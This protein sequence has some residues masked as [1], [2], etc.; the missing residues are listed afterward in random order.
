MRYTSILLLL[1]IN[2]TFAQ[3]PVSQLKIYLEKAPDSSKIQI[4]LKISKAYE[5]GR[6]DSAI[7]YCSKGIRLAEIQNNE[8]EQALFLLQIGRI[9]TI[10]FQAELGRKFENEA[11]LT[12]MRIR[13]QRGIA[14]CYS[15]LALVDGLEQDTAAT[16]RNFDKAVEIYRSVHDKDGVMET[17][18]REGNFYEE[19]GET[20]NALRYYLQAYAMYKRQKEK[21]E[22]YFT[23]I[24]HIGKLYLKKGANDTAQHYL[25]EG[26]SNVNTA[27]INN[28]QLNLIDEEGKA[29]EIER[30]NDRALLY[31]KQELATAKKANNFEQQAKALVS[32]AEILMKENTSQSIITLQNALSIAKDFNLP[33]LESIIYKALADDYRLKK[34]YKDAMTA[35]EEHEYLLDSLMNADTTMEVAELD[36]SYALEISR[37]Q[38]S[39]LQNITKVERKELNWGIMVLAAVVIIL[40][41]L[42]LYLTKISRLNKELKASNRVKDTL[43]SIIGH[44]L[45]GPAGSASQLFELIETE[46]FSEKELRGMITEIGKQTKES[47]ELLNALFE[48]GKSQMLGV[49]VK[50]IN[51]ATKKI[52][53]KNMALLLPQAVLKD[54]T[55]SDR[56]PPDISI[57]A[58]PNHFD[59][60]IRNLLSNAIKFTFDHGK[61]EI[62]ASREANG[63]TIIFS[64][65]DNGTGISL[66]QQQDF[67][68]QILLYL[69]VLKEK[70]A[71]ALACYSLKSIY[72]KTK[73]RYGWKVLKVREQLSFFLFRY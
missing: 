25:Q 2:S 59:F 58:D 51:F 72:R 48:W 33:E 44:D 70:K 50:P 29:F 19:R 36:S 62:N 45:K 18:A 10:H 24:N 13:D 68:K 8:K 28:A 11:L 39:D 21:P 9:N 40:T 64:V 43:F 16:M 65:K 42:W 38:I 14:L 57:F 69:L 47:F 63:R 20:E 71:V 61:I 73:A 5:I 54:I 55:I 15:E 35:L 49:I 37:Q 60:I 17:Y 27:A 52:I 67:L 30:K 41:L 7:D 32:I 12:F 6:P 26:L 22:A 46:E 4:Y 3:E 23:V 66:K 34:D 53:N 31:Y 56:T 1:I